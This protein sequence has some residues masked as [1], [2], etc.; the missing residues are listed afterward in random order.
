MSVVCAQPEPNCF[1]REGV[2]NWVQIE[3]TVDAALQAG[4]A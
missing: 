3:Q 2:E 4:A 1:Y